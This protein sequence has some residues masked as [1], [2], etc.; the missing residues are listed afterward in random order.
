[1][2]RAA[3]H[4]FEFWDFGNAYWFDDPG[5]GEMI[6]QGVQDYYRKHK[7]WNDLHMSPD[8]WKRHYDETMEG[9]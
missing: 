5:S 4:W 9:K 3:G 7:Y 1:M 8:A 2:T 6:D